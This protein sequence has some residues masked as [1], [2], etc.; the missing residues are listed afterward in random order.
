MRGRL[1]SASASRSLFVKD[2]ETRLFISAAAAFVKVRTRSSLISV[3]LSMSPAMR[4]MRSVRTAVL[5]LPAAAE[6]RRFLFLVSSASCCAGVQWLAIVILL[7]WFCHIECYPWKLTLHIFVA[8]SMDVIVI[9]FPAARVE[10][11]DGVV[12]AVLAGRASLKRTGRIS[13]LPE[14]ISS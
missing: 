4:V 6:S 2:A 11:A 14:I 10:A 1:F 12:W 9:F 7:S 5:P 13:I 3:P 8:D